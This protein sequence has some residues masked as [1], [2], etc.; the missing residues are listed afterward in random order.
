MCVVC[1][2]RDWLSDKVPNHLRNTQAIWCIWDDLYRV[3]ELSQFL[4]IV[5]G[6]GKLSDPTKLQWMCCKFAEDVMSEQNSAPNHRSFKEQSVT[7]LFL[8]RFQLS[9]ALFLKW[10]VFLE[11]IHWS[12]HQW[13]HCWTFVFRI[14]WVCASNRLHL[15]L[16]QTLFWA[17]LRELRSVP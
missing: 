5:F 10:S 1:P 3:S 17:S 2:I 11:W 7:Q 13:F 4:C 6:H 16:I 12:I 14:D 15:A 8:K 9:Y